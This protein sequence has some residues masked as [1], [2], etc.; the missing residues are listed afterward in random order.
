MFY[1]VYFPAVIGS[2]SI[3]TITLYDSGFLALI[4]NY[5]TTIFNR[6]K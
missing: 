1:S 5:T 4:D 3:P 6:F 2:N